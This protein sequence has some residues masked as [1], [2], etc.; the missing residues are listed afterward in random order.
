M[1]VT[2]LI[3]QAFANDIGIAYKIGNLKH[4]FYVPVI[5][6]IAFESGNAKEKKA[7]VFYGLGDTRDGGSPSPSKIWPVFDLVKNAVSQY[8]LVIPDFG[9]PYRDE[10]I[11]AL[12]TN[13]FV[14]FSIA[15]EKWLFSK[16]G[17]TFHNARGKIMDAAARIISLLE[18]PQE[19]LKSTAIDV[20]GT[21]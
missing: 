2:S 7:L 18:A 11:K 21:I 6:A 14:A 19:Y 10:I 1:A 5:L 9:E 16:S 13:V 12:P 15:E 4:C 20:L 17:P 3:H 8:E